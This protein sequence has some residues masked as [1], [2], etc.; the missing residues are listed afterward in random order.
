MSVALSAKRKGSFKID[1]PLDPANKYLYHSFVESPVMKNIYDGTVVTDGSGTAIRAQNRL[2][3]A[4]PRTAQM[5]VSS[6]ATLDAACSPALG[7]SRQRHAGG[8]QR[9]R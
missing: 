7:L 3:R 4:R 6:S 5:A 2:Y 1:H 9:W 8:A